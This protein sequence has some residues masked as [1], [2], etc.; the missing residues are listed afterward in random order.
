MSIGIYALVVDPRRTDADRPRGGQH[1]AL[2][3]MAI[4][5]HQTPAAIVDLIA[6][7]INVGS[8]LGGQRRREHLPSAIADDLVEQ[9]S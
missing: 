5:H 2:V 7:L 9:R 8:D 3:M 6:E 1:V 4:A